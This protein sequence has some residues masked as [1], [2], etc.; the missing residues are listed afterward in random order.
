MLQVWW[1]HPHHGKSDFE[2]RVISQQYGQWP[3]FVS[4]A[5]QDGEVFFFSGW[6]LTSPWI[7]A[8]F[9]QVDF[10]TQNGG[11]ASSA[12]LQLPL[13]VTSVV[14]KLPS[15]PWCA[16]LGMPPTL[17]SW[18]DRLLQI[19]VVCKMRLGPLVW[20]GSY[21]WHRQYRIALRHYAS[22]PTSTLI[23]RDFQPSSQKP[24]GI[25]SSWSMTSNVILSSWSHMRGVLNQF[26]QEA[27]LLPGGESLETQWLFLALP[28]KKQIITEIGCFFSLNIIFTIFMYWV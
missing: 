19:P 22:H 20:S 15:H 8:T 4:M 2:A 10:P 7:H 28:P 27:E 13:D 6:L 26:L 12:T 11:G 1:N 9:T 14:S 17:K 18:R 21:V 24:P 16:Y 3:W 25:A 23:W 5:R